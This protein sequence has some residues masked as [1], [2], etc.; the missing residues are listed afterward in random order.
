MHKYTDI[1]HH[2]VIWLKKAN[3]E[4]RLDISPPYQRNPVWSAKQKSSLI[5]TI[6]LEYP[7]P[8]IYMQ[9]IVDENGSERHVVVDGQQRIRSVLKFVS[10]EFEI[11]EEGSRW[12]GFSFDELSSDDKKKIF[13]YK[14]L[15][16]IL[17]DMGDDQI[18][19]IFQRINRNTTVLNSQELRRATYWGPFIRLM[20]MIS[21]LEV[22]NQFGLFSSNDKRR[23]LDTEFVSEIAVAVIFGPQNKK[24]RLDDCY[25]IFETEFPQEEDVHSIFLDVLGEIRHIIPELRQTRF[26]KKSDFY[27]LFLVVAEFKTEIPF[28]KEIRAA[29]GGALTN[30]AQAV[31]LYDPV[32]EFAA[33]A[34]LQD[35]VKGVERAASDLGPRRLRARALKYIVELAIQG[36]YKPI[37]LPEIEDFAGL[38]IDFGQ[39]DA[40]DLDNLG[41]GDPP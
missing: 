36:E 19:H 23:M 24:S 15:V 29:L 22:W 6:L 31:N 41:S 30:F 5:E 11:I 10:G 39:I 9:D 35:Y 14:F 7:I 38:T 25:R 34:P 4:G 32:A 37:K 1:T 28:S 40:D 8:E 27:T 2:S 17:P 21:D 33:W 12:N 20:E 26:R 13:E 16:R 3:D 18:R